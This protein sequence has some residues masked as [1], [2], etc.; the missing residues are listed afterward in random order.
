MEAISYLER[1]LQLEP[2]NTTFKLAY[3]EAGLKTKA[4]GQISIKGRRQRVE[5]YEV[6]GL[7]DP[8]KD[9]LRIPPRIYERC[10]VVL[11]ELNIPNDVTLPSEVIDG[12][13][14]HSRVVAALSYVIAGELGLSEREKLDVM[15]AGFPRRHRQGSDTPLH[16]QPPRRTP[17]ERARHGQAASR[18]SL[19]PDAEH[20]L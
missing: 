13:V 19:P 7:K 4:Q 3:A 6:L 17:G 2:G 18:G 9:P 20:G 11:D 16:P 15:R 12:S 5:A 10:N 8:L 1:A 14:G